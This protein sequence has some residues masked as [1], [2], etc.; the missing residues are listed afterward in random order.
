MV[1]GVRLSNSCVIS[2]IRKLLLN[3]NYQLMSITCTNEA[4]ASS[5]CQAI[6]PNL[7]RLGL[8]IKIKTNSMCSHVIFIVFF[9]FYMEN[10]GGDGFNEFL[11][12]IPSF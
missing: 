11:M 3:Y 1:N 5:C 9:K 10:A 7:A 2:F 4:S 12:D 8:V 6:L